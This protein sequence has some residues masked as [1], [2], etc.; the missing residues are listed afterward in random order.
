MERA[1]FI[2]AME[3]GLSAKRLADY[4]RFVIESCAPLSLYYDDDHTDANGNED[5]IK[6]TTQIKVRVP[7]LQRWLHRCQRQ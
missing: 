4:R 2:V 1:R 6:V 7:L 3:D 5:L